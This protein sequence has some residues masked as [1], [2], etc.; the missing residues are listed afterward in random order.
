M[1][2]SGRRFALE[3]AFL[4]G[5]GVAVGL[6]GLS[7]GRIIGVMALGWLLTVLVEL[8]SWR[9]AVRH[10][11]GIALPAPAASAAADAAAA[12]P[13]E[14]APHAAAEHLPE[15]EEEAR[16]EEH[17]AGEDAEPA[18]VAEEDLGPPVVEPARERRRSFW[19]RRAV[20]EAEPEPPPRHVRLIPKPPGEPDGDAEV[21]AASAERAEGA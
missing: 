11:T 9:L 13:Q 4:A 7:T 6:A 10:P 5:L 14:E 1:A 21:P 2:G 18:P 8:V 15:H 19:R 3:A 20:Q 16:P 12:M 17:P